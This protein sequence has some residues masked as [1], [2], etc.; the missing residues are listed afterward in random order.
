MKPWIGTPPRTT[1]FSVQALST[2]VVKGTIVRSNLQHPQ[3]TVGKRASTSL[4]V[5]PRPRQMGGRKP[6][7]MT[8]PLTVGRG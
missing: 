7:H 4:V 3:A 5:T 2:S 8:S 6:T 1:G